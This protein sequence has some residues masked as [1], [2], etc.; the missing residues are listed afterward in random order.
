MERPGPAREISSR[1]VRS[2]ERPRFPLPRKFVDRPDPRRSD[3][4]CPFELPFPLRDPF[5]EALAPAGENPSDAC[6]ASRHRSALAVPGQGPGLLLGGGP[7]SWSG[8]RCGGAIAVSPPPR[9]T[10]A[11]RVPRSAP[12]HLRGTGSSARSLD[13]RS[14]IKPDP[15]TAGPAQLAPRPAA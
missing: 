3:A 2:N 14:S 11:L 6:L 9:R 12:H 1:G 13:A 10:Q 15:S 5:G 4:G 7:I 8:R